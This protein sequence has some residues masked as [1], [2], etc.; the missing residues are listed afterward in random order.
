[1]PNRT[2]EHT[3][4]VEETTPTH[5]DTRPPRAGEPLRLQ[6]S[7]CGAPVSAHLTSP[8]LMRTTLLVGSCPR[9][10][11]FN[12]VGWGTPAPDPPAPRK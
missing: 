8:L 11:C 2:L 10:G 7:R 4:A 5:W 3:V 12:T 1:M 6:C 9:C